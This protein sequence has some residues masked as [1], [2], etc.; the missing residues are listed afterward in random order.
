MRTGW[1]TG[2]SRLAA[3]DDY[4]PLGSSGDGCPPPG[5]GGGGRWEGSDGEEEPDP[6]TVTATATMFR[7][8]VRHPH[9]KIAIFTDTSFQTVGRSA[10][11][12]H[13]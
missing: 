7:V 11:E 2:S 3:A 5:S 6:T 9:A 10:R 4:P 1:A 8:Q 12:N 13:F